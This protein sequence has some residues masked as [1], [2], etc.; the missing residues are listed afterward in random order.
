MAWSSPTIKL[1]PAQAIFSDCNITELEIGEE[2]VGYQ[3]T[4]KGQEI[5]HKSLTKL[6]GILWERANEISTNG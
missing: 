4:H 5:Q 1:S 2:T 3:A 6:C